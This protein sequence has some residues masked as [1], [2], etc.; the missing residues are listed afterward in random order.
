MWQR[1]RFSICIE[2]VQLCYKKQTAFPVKRAILARLK[3]ADD[4]AAE[5]A[6]T[7]IITRQSTLLS[8]ELKGQKT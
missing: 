6:K 1:D 2:E 5:V 8:E 3:K 7:G 4:F